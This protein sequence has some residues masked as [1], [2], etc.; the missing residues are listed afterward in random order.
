[1]VSSPSET[2]ALA[3]EIDRLAARVPLEAPWDAPDAVDLDSVTFA[4]WLEA[5][6][7][8][9]AIREVRPIRGFLGDFE[10]FSLLHLLFYSRSNGG[11][12]S[13]IGIGERH[14]TIAFDG[15]L[16]VVAERVADSLGESIRYEA[17]VR[18]VLEEGTGLSIEARGRRTRARRC[19]VAIPPTLASGISFD[20]PLIGERDELN[21]RMPLFTQIKAQILYSEPFWRAGGMSGRAVTE[22]VET[23]DTSPIDGEAAVLTVLSW[24]SDTTRDLG[25]LDPESRKRAILAEVASL[26][27]AAGM[28]PVAYVDRSWGDDPYSR[29]CVMSMPP[30]VWTGPAD[31]SAGPAAR[32]TRPARRRRRSSAPTSRGRSGPGKRAASEVLAALGL[33]LG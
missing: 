20:P 32:S 33:R 19:I 4:S 11:V 23:F 12:G 1:M 30:G 13:L 18:E 3:A 25:R 17:P 16:H 21:R 2:V 22:V 31:R 6:A 14:D 26:W 5:N 28:H 15:A 7:T 27:G 24:A 8:A 9:E 10:H 29:G